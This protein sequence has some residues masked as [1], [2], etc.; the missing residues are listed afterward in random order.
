MTDVGKDG[1]VPGLTGESRYVVASAQTVPAL[2]DDAPLLAAMP[3]VLATAYLVALMER[4]CIECMAPHYEEGQIS[5]GISMDMTH[6]AP[7][8]VGDE[9]VIHVSCTSVEK[10]Q[11]TWAIEARTGDVIVGRAKHRRALVAMARFLSGLPAARP[12]AVG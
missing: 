2:F 3:S 10:R 1:I 5:L 4:A 7:N 8:V 9:V 11:S 12:G 6:D